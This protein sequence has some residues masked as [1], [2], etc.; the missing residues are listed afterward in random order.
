MAATASWTGYTVYLG[1]AALITKYTSP[2]MHPVFGAAYALGVITLVGGI[3]YIPRLF[4]GNVYLEK[5]ISYPTLALSAYGTWRLLNASGNIATPS[6]VFITIFGS[7][8]CAEVVHLALG[9]AGKKR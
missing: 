3:T 6:Q 5:L 4:I 7:Y 2:Q 9:R 8:M 1:A